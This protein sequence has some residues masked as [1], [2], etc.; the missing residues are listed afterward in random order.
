PPGDLPGGA[1]YLLY[2]LLYPERFA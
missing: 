1:A 2:V